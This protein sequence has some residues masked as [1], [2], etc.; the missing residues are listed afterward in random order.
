MDPYT[1]LVSR[2]LDVP[3]LKERV[4]D[5]PKDLALNLVNLDWKERLQQS[6]LY[7]T[8]K[9]DA[10]KLY[11]PVRL[12]NGFKVQYLQRTNLSTQIYVVGVCSVYKSYNN[13][14]K[15]KSHFAIQVH[16]CEALN[17]LAVAMTGDV[18]PTSVQLSD[19]AKFNF[20]PCSYICRYCQ[21]ARDQMTHNGLKLSVE[22]SQP[23]IFD[24]EMFNGTSVESCFAQQ[25]KGYLQSRFVAIMHLELTTRYF[26]NSKN[27]GEVVRIGGTAIRMIAFPESNLMM[28]PK[29]SLVKLS[30]LKPAPVVEGEAPANKRQLVLDDEEEEEVVINALPPT[31]AAK[32]FKS[33]TDP[34]DS[35]DDTVVKEEKIYF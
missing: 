33:S 28:S 27:D 19:T 23:C 10:K 6:I 24:I 9:H 31:A 13:A 22:V 21:Q 8:L 11:T 32:H 2:V 15:N 25:I 5:W 1:S 14:Y 16:D 29:M 20:K 7:K 17:M 12:N 4:T 18:D 34:W 3:V 26:Y 35:D 30:M